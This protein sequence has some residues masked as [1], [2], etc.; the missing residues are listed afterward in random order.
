MKRLIYIIIGLLGMTTTQAQDIKERILVETDKDFYLAGER[1]G[2][3][4]HTTDAQGKIQEFSRVAYVEL[5]GDK[6][7]AV[8]L[9]VEIKEGTGE[10]IMQLPY[11]LASG[12][13]DLVVY[14]RWM[15][16]EG[17]QVFFRRQI[18]VFNS[19]RYIRDT[20][21]LVFM[22]GESSVHAV[23]P[24]NTG[25]QVKT[26]KLQYSNREKVILALEGVPE[27]ALLSVSVVRKDI[28]LVKV[29]E[30]QPISRKE[31][32]DKAY[33]PEVEGLI[34]ETRLEGT[35]KN[36]PIV[37][38]N[39]TIQGS[40][41]HYY[42]GQQAEDG[43][44]L[45]YT[46]SLPGVKEVVTATNGEGYLQPIS[47]FVATPPAEMRPITLYRQYETPLTERSI[48]LQVTEH[49]YLKE[50]PKANVTEDQLTT[51]TPKWTFD[52]DHYK[53]FPT[54]E[55]TFIEFMPCVKTQGVKGNRRI[56]AFDSEQQ[57][58][59]NGNTLVLLD[60]VSIMN[61][62]LLLAYDPHLVKLVEVYVE[63]FAFGDQLYNGILSVKTPN[64]KLSSFTLPKT[65]VVCDYEGVQADASYPMPSAGKEVQL[66]L[67]DFRHTLYWNGHVTGKDSLLTFRTSDM[68]GT[69]IVKVEGR[70]TDGKAI[71]GYT[72]FDVKKEFQQ[73]TSTK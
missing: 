60:G 22:E 38:P 35:E 8:R 30:D 16:N 20:D 43:L 72:S 50:T 21:R 55:E 73:K 31:K 26:D 36:I 4:F 9:K 52:L 40:H 42:A 67:P 15:R 63:D 45:F 41:I 65:S 58:S 51:A 57:A 14:T 48:A 66:H 5:L 23:L 62:E 32:A 47:P 71:R 59:G 39:L 1:I 18:G 19:L 70:T 69:Y 28:A 29:V 61:H 44:V 49:F 34:L 11:T 53:R 17:E 54:F 12:M 7:N 56:V 37:R 25:I 46:T 64:C 6:E 24:D 27:N 68:C 2:L 3:K 33:Q 13:Y 10:A